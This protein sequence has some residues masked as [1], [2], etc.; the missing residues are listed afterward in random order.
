[1]TDTKTDRPL[2]SEPMTAGAG[3]PAGEDRPVNAW[4]TGAAVVV[5]LFQL[6][7]LPLVLLP[8]GGGWGWLLVPLVPLT[9]PFWSL[10]HEAIH[11]TLIRRRT[12]NDR[13]GRVLS[14]LYGSPF[15]LLKTGHLLHHRYSRTRRE[16]S[17]IYDPATT[18]WARTA[19]GYYL[20]LLGGLYLLE[21][22]STLLAVLPAGRLRRLG[23]RL[24]TPDTVAG[25]LIE[26][27]AQPRV[28][29]QFRLDA[30][31][32]VVAYTMA[33]LAYG[34]HWWMLL[35]ALGG[36]ALVVSVSDNAYHYGTRLE[37]MLEAMNLRLP[38]ALEN[39]ALSFN[40]HDVHHRHPGL[41]WYELRGAF[42]A[43]GGH[44]HLGWFRAAGRQFRGPIKLR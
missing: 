10:I 3:R 5:N 15:V 23:R 44:Y 11:G 19:P 25:L 31:A 21:V 35:A 6:F 18:T 26:R 36:R 30:A 8:A 9:T 42:L 2:R 17:E 43:E 39:L 4:L 12:A 1:M 37:A 34:G 13:S 22:L 32:I 40:L 38:R 41:R 28:L 16:R 33:F 29:R 7:L 24:D 27:V 14:V 20:R